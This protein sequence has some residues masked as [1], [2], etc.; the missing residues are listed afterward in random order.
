MGGADDEEVVEESGGAD[1]E[2]ETLRRKDKEEEEECGV[3]VPLT[4]DLTDLE[5]EINNNVEIHSFE[6]L[7]TKTH[8]CRICK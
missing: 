1:G 6:N 7:N 4:T 2:A 5:K 8:A 3:V